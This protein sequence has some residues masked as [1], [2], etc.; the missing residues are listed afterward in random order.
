M[1]PQSIELDGLTLI[2]FTL[3]YVILQEFPLL[4]YALLYSNIMASNCNDIRLFGLVFFDYNATPKQK[5]SHPPFWSNEVY[6]KI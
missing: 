4:F 6:L 5:Q 3:L 1:V 2:Y